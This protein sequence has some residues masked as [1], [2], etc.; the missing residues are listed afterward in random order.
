[1][2]MEMPSQGWPATLVPSSRMSCVWTICCAM[3]CQADPHA[4]DMSPQLAVAWSDP[5]ISC[6]FSTPP[7][8]PEV[9][10]GVTCENAT[11]A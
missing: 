9:V 6:V 5:S 3:D 7:T 8:T 11:V 4:S 1:M 10:D 2:P